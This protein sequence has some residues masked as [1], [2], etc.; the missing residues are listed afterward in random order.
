MIIATLVGMVAC[1]S[2]YRHFWPIIN[3][4]LA[5][6]DVHKQAMTYTILPGRLAYEER[7][8][9]SGYPI[10]NNTQP[11]P[12]LPSDKT[13]IGPLTLAPPFVATLAAN[14]STLSNIVFS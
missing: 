14:G 9:G 6:A 13:E 3:R 5:I 4:N 2:A 7:W 11:A 12:W 1:I 10:W 8:S